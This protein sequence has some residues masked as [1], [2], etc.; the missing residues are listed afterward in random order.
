MVRH[1][2]QQQAFQIPPV[3]VDIQFVVGRLMLIFII[4][5][6]S[7]ALLEL[8]IYIIYIISH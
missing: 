7:K 3:A 8:S 4:Q 6:I 1:L 5:H 2:S